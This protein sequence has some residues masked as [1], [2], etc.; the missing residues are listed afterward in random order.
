LDRW[1]RGC[2]HYVAVECV[3]FLIEEVVPR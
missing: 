3:P 2:E 1:E